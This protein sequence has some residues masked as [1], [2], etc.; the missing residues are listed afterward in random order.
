[1]KFVSRFEVPT[2]P[3]DPIFEMMRLPDGLVSF[4]T[5]QARSFTSPKV[6][7][8]FVSDFDLNTRGLVEPASDQV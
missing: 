1:M 2:E 5:F 4:R 7:Q 8:F 3:Y 6:F